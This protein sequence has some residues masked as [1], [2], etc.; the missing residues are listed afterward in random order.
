MSYVAT[1]YMPAC[2]HL[3]VCL[4]ALHSTMDVSKTFS[5]ALPVNNIRMYYTHGTG[6]LYFKDSCIDCLQTMQML[7]THLT[8]GGEFGKPLDTEL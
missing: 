3:L 2:T 7:N 8:L 1:Y 4:D 5:W 6:C